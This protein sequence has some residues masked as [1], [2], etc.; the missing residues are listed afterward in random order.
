MLRVFSTCFL[1][2]LL[3]AISWARVKSEME[4][5]TGGREAFPQHVAPFPDLTAIMEPAEDLMMSD[6]RP[7][8]PPRKLRPIRYNGRSPASSQ[9]EDHSEFA[10]A[11]ELVGDEVC[12]INGSSF[13]YLTPPI[14]AEVGDVTATVGG[15]GNGVEGPPSSEQRGEPS[16]YVCMFITPSTA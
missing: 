1:I 9:A 11:V 10:E 15:G 8:L 5:F 12:A 2:Q 7:T 3:R 6:H 4:L 16:G 14:K 13:D